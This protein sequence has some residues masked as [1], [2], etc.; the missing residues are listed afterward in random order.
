MGL[1]LW[2][3]DCVEA[4]VK[5]AVVFLLENKQW[6]NLDNKSNKLLGNGMAADFKRAYVDMFEGVL[7]DRKAHKDTMDFKIT[8]VDGAS[9]R[10]L[11]RAKRGAIGT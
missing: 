4:L 10:L 5:T 6:A 7:Y 2:C 8:D 1:S 3:P 11:P 9:A